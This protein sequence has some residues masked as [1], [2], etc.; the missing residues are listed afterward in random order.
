MATAFQ[1]D[2]FQNNAFQIDLAT[3]IGIGLFVSLMM[4]PVRL[5]G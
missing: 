2:A 1:A 4:L 3:V 5:V